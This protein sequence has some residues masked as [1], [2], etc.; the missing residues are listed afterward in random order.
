MI[1]DLYVDVHQVKNKSFK[2]CL[3]DKQNSE[4]ATESCYVTSFYFILVDSS[5]DRSRL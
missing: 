4:R 5:Q 1:Y 2:F 3:K